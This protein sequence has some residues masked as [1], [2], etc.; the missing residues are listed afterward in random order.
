MAA[1]QAN[2]GGYVDDF[3]VEVGVTRRG[4]KLPAGFLC[5]DKTPS[6][7]HANLNK[8]FRVASVLYFV[9]RRGLGPDKVC[10]RGGDTGTSTQASSNQSQSARWRG[11]WL[12]RCRRPRRGSS[13]L[14]WSLF[15]ASMDPVTVSLGTHTTR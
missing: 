13:T 3:L 11:D 2:G 5:V 6:G 10:Q 4:E 14:P 1:A 12:G 8:G 15:L 9:A 7:Q